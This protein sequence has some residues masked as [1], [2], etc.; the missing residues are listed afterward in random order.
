M[1]S[2]KIKLVQGDTRPQLI[3]SVTDQISKRPVDLSAAGTQV[4]LLFREVG[5]EDLKATMN[6]YPIVGY[7]NPETREVETQPPY[8]VPGR[9]GRVVMGWLPD[10]L[11]TA[12]EF[13]GEVETTFPDG[14]VQTVYETVRFTVREQFRGG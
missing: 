10:A 5:A 12:G 4:R 3:L 14:T 8:N 6:C 11:D 1:A 2:E 9:G 7:L 13:E